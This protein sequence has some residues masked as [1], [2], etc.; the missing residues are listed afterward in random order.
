MACNMKM[1]SI[2]EIFKSFKKE[3]QYTEEDDCNVVLLMAALKKK[4][5][6]MYV[7]R[8]S[9]IH[10]L[11]SD[12]AFKPYAAGYYRVTD[13]YDIKSTYNKG[14]NKFYVYEQGKKIPFYLINYKNRIGTYLSTSYQLESIVKLVRYILY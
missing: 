10:P 1:K 13:Y 12:F 4:K 11:A 14:K 2:K 3:K 5:R 9:S 6:M 7:E 8:Y